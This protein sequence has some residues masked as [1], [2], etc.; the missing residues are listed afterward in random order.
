[1]CPVLIHAATSRATLLGP[2][3]Y[4]EVVEPRAD[5]PTHIIFAFN[6]DI[7]ALDNDFE[8]SEQV[9]VTNAECSGVDP[10]ANHN[11]LRVLP[12]DVVDESIV[13]VTLHRITDL[14]GSPVI[15]DNGVAIVAL[16]EGASQN[17][18]VKNRYVEIV[19]NHAGERTNSDNF[20]AGLNHSGRVLVTDHKIVTANWGHTVP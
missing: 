18:L 3:P 10:S 4:L 8:C 11:Q 13:H 16:E 7:T 15:D 2:L 14:V 6:K 5:G 1:M 19:D 9:T 12:R 17:R 20:L